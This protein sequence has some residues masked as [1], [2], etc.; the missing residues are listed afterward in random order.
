VAHRGIDHYH[1]AGEAHSPGFLRKYTGKP[2]GLNSPEDIQ[3]GI[4]Y[5]HFSAGAVT[6]FLR[7]TGRVVI[8]PVEDT[9]KLEVV[10][11]EEDPEFLCGHE[12]AI[13]LDWWACGWQPGLSRL[14]KAVNEARFGQVGGSDLERW[15]VAVGFVDARPQVSDVL[16]DK[17]ADS[18]WAD[19]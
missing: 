8:D 14:G 19:Q 18:G 2:T 3:L 12:Q 17:F 16:D 1:S 11:W 9:N 15:F 6:P 5:H 4:R 7:I 10:C 13:I